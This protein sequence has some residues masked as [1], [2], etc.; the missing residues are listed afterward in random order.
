MTS[1][2]RK[3]TPAR[4]S[5][6][7][8]TTRKQPISDRRRSGR[9]PSDLSG[10]IHWGNRLDCLFKCRVKDMSSTGARLLI[11]AQ[12]RNFSMD[13]IANRFTLVVVHPREE[14]HIECAV[15]RVSGTE[16]GV[17]FMGQFRTV[18]RTKLTTMLIGTNG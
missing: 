12:K 9:R 5:L 7:S 2:T 1:A 6:Q 14:I 15:M 4:A 16:V 10:Y 13:M 11:E 17:R 3:D 8:P 18:K